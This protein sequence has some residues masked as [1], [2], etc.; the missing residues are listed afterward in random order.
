MAT[1]QLPF[2]R[3]DKKLISN[4]GFDSKIGR[5][6]GHEVPNYFFNALLSR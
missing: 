4:P 3:D 2:G 1:S 5:G 6:I